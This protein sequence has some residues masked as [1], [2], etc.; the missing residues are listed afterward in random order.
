MFTKGPRK[1]DKDPI[2]GSW[3]VR[4]DPENWNGM[5]YQH[6]CILP[7]E[8]KGTHYG[9]MF[10]ANAHLIAA[11]PMMVEALEELKETVIYTNG[12]CMSGCSRCVKKLEK[13][14]EKAEAVLRLAKAERR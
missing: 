12:H 6:I 5:G 10:K 2:C 1:C 9:D 4:Q 7:A 3:F 13:A 14:I 8:K 11:A